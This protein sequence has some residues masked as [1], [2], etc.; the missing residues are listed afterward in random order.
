MKNKHFLF[1]CFF[2]FGMLFALPHAWIN[3]IHYD[4]AGVDKN[5]FVEV[6][7]ENP[8]NHYL[9]DL[10]LY[11]Y[12]GYDGIPYCL[13]SIDEFDQGD[14]EGQFQFYTWYQRGIQND[15]EGMVLVFKDTIL[16]ILAYEGSFT[17]NNVPAD[18][19]LFPDIG[20]QETGSGPDTNAIYLLG[21]PGSEWD[22][23]PVSP[24]S[25][26]PGQQLSDNPSPLELMD[27][28]A[29]YKN[30][31]V[32]LSWR[33][34]SESE[35]IRFNLYKNGRLLTW[36]N[37]SGTTNEM[38]EYEFIDRLT[39]AGQ[40]VIYMLGETSVGQP[41]VMLDTVKLIIPSQYDFVLKSP[42]PNPTN[43]ELNIPISVAE[44]GPLR[45]ELFDMNG[46]HVKT[47]ANTNIKAGDHLFNVITS[48]L[49]SGRY[50]VACKFKDHKFNTGISILK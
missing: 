31:N 43:P 39:I 28:N 20:I 1:I 35:V 23:G 21:M 11:M 6:V 12:N 2:M 27:F 7:V 3:E 22:Y 37:A 49:A 25:L 8:E 47:I 50:I 40:K 9:G 26:N 32:H 42:F 5:E 30:G 15:M 38:H 48:E 41:V 34:A 14:R 4:N 29:E 44:S 16:D 13:D 19:E 10:V 46:R 36:L 33:T 24:G 17:G 18:G 45:L